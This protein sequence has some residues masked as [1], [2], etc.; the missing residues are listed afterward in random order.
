MRNKSRK[1]HTVIASRDWF[2]CW[3]RLTAYSRNRQLLAPWF[4]Y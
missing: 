3:S 4:Q 2:F 1:N